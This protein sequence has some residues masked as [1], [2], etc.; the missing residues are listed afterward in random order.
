MLRERTR[1]TRGKPEGE[2]I[3]PGDIPTC[4]R[5]RIIDVRTDVM[6]GWVGEVV[7]IAPG[8]AMLRR[9]GREPPG[10]I[11]TSMSCSGSRRRGLPEATSTGLNRRIDLGQCFGGVISLKTLLR[12]ELVEVE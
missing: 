11:R 8:P 2:N 12:V 6:A 5:T 4:R 3:C 10:G 1:N 9:Y 7:R